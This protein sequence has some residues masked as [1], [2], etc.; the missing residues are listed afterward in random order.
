MSASSSA[1][2]PVGAPDSKAACTIAS[3]NASDDRDMPNSRERSL[4]RC[5]SSRIR[6]F[7]VA[8][9]NSICRC[10]KVSVYSSPKGNS[11]LTFVLI[12]GEN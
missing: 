6:L 9:P 5:S 2:R 11:Y 4:S 3:L 12:R 7:S 10:S 8:V 1:L